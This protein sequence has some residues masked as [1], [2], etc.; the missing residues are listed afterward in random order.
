MLYLLNDSQQM[1][2]AVWEHST[3]STSTEI[4]YQELLSGNEPQVIASEA[5]IHFT[6]PKILKVD[7]TE[8]LFYVFYQGDQAGNQ[9]L[10]YLK[11]SV[12]GQFTGPF[13][14][15]TT[16]NDETS[17]VV[18]ND[19]YYKSADRYMLTVLT[20]TSNGALMSCYLEKNGEVY[21]F[22]EP[23]IIDN[24][25]CSDPVIVNDYSIFYI[26][27]NEP[28]RFIYFVSRLPSNEWSEP[29]LYFDQG[30]CY[31]L[32]EDNVMTQFLAWSADSNGTYRNIIA[33]GDVFDGY[34]IGPV[35][36]TP[37]DPAV[38]T[39]VIAVKS[40]PVD[41]WEFYL[42]FPYQAEGHDE[43]FMN[44]GYN[45]P[46]GFGNFTQSGLENR[47]PEFYPGE[48]HPWEW[49]C[50]YVYLTWEEYRNDHWQ[51]WYS[52]VKMCAG[53]IDDQ[54]DDPLSF[55]AYPNPF[56]DEI[57]LKFK[58]SSDD[59]VLM[60][61]YDIYGRKIRELY[62]GQMEKGEKKVNWN[63]ES[64]PPGIYMIR[65]QTPDNQSSIRVMKL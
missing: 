63:D 28:G 10:Y 65:L 7:G 52:K 16:N 8:F 19:T 53:G 56:R 57:S 23:V 41:F 60:E 54:G 50:F 4:Y 38:C 48:V 20:W 1:V 36:E 47:N 32:A 59:F 9:D 6:H 61:V 29:A 39:I 35:G 37:L 11:Y 2:N 22:S 46:P 18:G 49:W 42:A 24:G 44:D 31:N 55:E 17:L 12:D 13:P 14:F 58:L 51:I 26:R 21:S 40:Q 15:A 27:D 43:I 5:G 34:A 64:T 30:N 62:E 33:H 3:D 45:F 25:A